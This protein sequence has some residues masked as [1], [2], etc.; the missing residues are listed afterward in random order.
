MVVF[1]FQNCLLNNMWNGSYVG[2]C[3]NLSM[4]TYGSPH[5]FQQ[6]WADQAEPF[7]SA[8][9]QV[10]CA[11]EKLKICFT[12]FSSLPMSFIACLGSLLLCFIGFHLVFPFIPCGKT[13]NIL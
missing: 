12:R 7:M 9:F 10:M 8:I 5:C 2:A 3:K 6:R 1:S 13:F 4:L 11:R